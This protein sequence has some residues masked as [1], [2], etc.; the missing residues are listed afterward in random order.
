MGRDSQDVDRDRQSVA[1]FDDVGGSPAGMRMTFEVRSTDTGVSVAGRS[2]KW[3]PIAGCTST[4]LASGEE[5][6]LQ[7]EVGAG[8]EGPGDCAG[9]VDRGLAGRPAQEVPGGGTARGR[10]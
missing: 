7:Y 3:S 6:E 4:G 2:A 9:E 8:I 1:V 5:V 10:A